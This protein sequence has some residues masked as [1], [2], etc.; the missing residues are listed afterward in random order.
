[1]LRSVF[2]VVGGFGLWTVLWLGGNA[3]AQ[4]AMPDAFREDG[5]TDQ[6]GMLCAI[7]AFSVICSIIAGYLTGVIAKRSAMTNGVVLGM[8]QLAVGIFVQSHYWDKM[9][10][11]IVKTLKAVIET[12]R[13]TFGIRMLYVLF[14]IL[15]PL[16]PKKCLSKN[17]P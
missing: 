3:A 12:G 6:V 16:T 5:S 9:P 8:I 11:M 10:A 14:K 17:W 2:S 15:A 13:P 7:L 1:M 4:A